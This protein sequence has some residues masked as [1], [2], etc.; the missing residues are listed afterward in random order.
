MSSV[1]KC[2]YCNCEHIA[3][4]DEGLNSNGK[5]IYE[6]DKTNHRESIF[7]CF[8]IIYSQMVFYGAEIDAHSSIGEFS[9]KIELDNAAHYSYSVV[10]KFTNSYTSGRH[11]YNIHKNTINIHCDKYITE[12][13]YFEFI[14]FCFAQ[15][16][17]EILN[18]CLE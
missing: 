13:N 15:A 11:K 5:S 14:G 6:C 17:K 9:I 7:Y 12:N 8:I 10:T 16:Q 3:W 4:A 1:I 18:K 2:G